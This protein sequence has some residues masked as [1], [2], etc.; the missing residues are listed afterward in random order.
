MTGNHVVFLFFFLG[1]GG[2]VYNGDK[3]HPSD[4][5]VDLSDDY[6]FDLG[7]LVLSL[8]PSVN[9]LRI[10]IVYIQYTCLCMHE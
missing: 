10:Y 2:G 6:A 5:E 3:S 9:R 7:F 4:Y 1:P 8:F